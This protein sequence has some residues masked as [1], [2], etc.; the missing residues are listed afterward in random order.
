MAVNQLTFANRFSID[1]QWKPREETPEELGERTL[2]CLDMITP[3]HPAFRNWTFL[4]LFRDPMEMT[5]ENIGEFLCPL[6][7]AR[8]QITDVVVKFGVDNDDHRTPEPRGGYNISVT[9]DNVD[10]SQ[11][12]TLSAHGGGLV[13]WTGAARHAS[14]ETGMTHEADPTIISYPVFRSVLMTII[15]CWDVDYASAGS[16]D[17]TKLSAGTHYFCGPSWMVYLSAPLARRI[18][19]P[20]DVTVERT[21]DGGILM[22]AAEETFD[23]NNPIHVARARSILAALEPLN[24]EEA[25]KIAQRNTW[26]PK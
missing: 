18:A 8:P 22:I 21:P 12:V 24:A 9:A 25:A 10:P 17:L 16:S 15:S 6:V 7:E 20:A 1:S 26:R 5:D 2:R 11:R 4:D 3:L 23:T 13:S 19:I 14:L